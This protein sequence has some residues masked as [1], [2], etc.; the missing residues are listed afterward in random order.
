[1]PKKEIKRDK[2]IY[3]F[4]EFQ[5]MRIKYKDILDLKAFYESLHEWLLEHEW[6]D[7]EEGNSP[8]TD[9]W[10]SYYG[11]KV[12]QGGSKELWIQW[13]VKKDPPDGAKLTYY[14]DFN[15]H[16]IALM[17]TDVVKEGIKMSVDKGEIEITIQAYMEENYKSDLD[18]VTFLKPFREWIAQR[19]YSET[20]D[21]RKKE[22][23]QETYELQNWMKQWLKL[24]RYLPYEESKG[25]FTSQAW[26]SHLKEE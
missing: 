16:G 7:P 9:H 18:R 17:K 1:M 10:E 5:P 3:V 22:L 25:F 14:L 21:Q 15:W 20:V 26:P 23:Y 11:E 4:S 24:K 6:Y 2:L 19:L 12:A 8:A 13:R